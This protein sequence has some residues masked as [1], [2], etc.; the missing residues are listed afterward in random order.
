MKSIG[1]KIRQAT[2]LIDTKDVSDWE[3]QF[4]KDMRRKTNDGER[5]THLTEKQVGAIENIYG[6]HFA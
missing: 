5:T 1:Q 6:K 2:A 4:L 3:N